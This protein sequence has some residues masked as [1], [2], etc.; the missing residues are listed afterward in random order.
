MEIWAVCPSPSRNGWWYVDLGHGIDGGATAVLFSTSETFQT[1]WR[2]RGKKTER[3]NSNDVVN[4]W[5]MRV[6]ALSYCLY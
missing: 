3:S 2:D 6:A 1:R 4:R 5:Q